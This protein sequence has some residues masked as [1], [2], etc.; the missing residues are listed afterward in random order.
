MKPRLKLEYFVGDLLIPNLSGDGDYISARRADLNHYLTVYELKY[1]EMLLG[2]DLFDEFSDA[3]DAAGDAYDSLAAK[4][5]ALV[6]QIYPAEQNT[7]LISAAAYY[8]YFKYM[9][10]AVTLTLDSGQSTP[11]HENATAGDSVNK[12]VFAWNRC[13]E[14]SDDLAEWL[15]DNIDTYTTYATPVPYYLKP[16]NRFGI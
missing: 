15:I 8:V 14:L 1:L 4:W 11:T 7:F 12:L 6:D 16:I 3:L 9:R 2:E 10:D 5:Q 13:V